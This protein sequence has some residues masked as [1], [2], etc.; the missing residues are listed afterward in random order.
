MIPHPLVLVIGL[1]S[2]FGLTQSVVRTESQPLANNNNQSTPF[3][4]IQ[5][6]SQTSLP[7]STHY[8]VGPRPSPTNTPTITPSPWS[9]NALSTYKDLIDYCDSNQVDSSQW[10]LALNQ[11]SFPS[12]IS[13]ETQE[14]L[15]D[16]VI[17]R[18]SCNFILQ[19]Q[20]RAI[21]L[22]Y[23][24]GPLDATIST[25][26]QPHN[27]SAHYVIDRDGKV[28]QIVPER[29]AAFHVNCYG[30]RNLCIPSC[31][32]CENS[33]GSFVEPRTQTIGI[34]LVNLGHVDPRYYAGSPSAEND[35]LYEDYNNSFGYRFWED[36]PQA[37]IHSLQILVED[38]RSRWDIPLS[39][40]MGHS[41]INNNADPGPALNLFWFRYGNPSREAI[42]MQS[43]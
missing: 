10:R 28:Y 21:V 16:R 43:F 18:P 1:L 20:P 38:I 4:E 5:A 17:I 26:Q 27:S 37:Q 25:F 40:V 24:E 35:G 31:P 23:T 11:V 14:D 7:S 42:F 22:H 33:E 41:R 29:F 12:D 19:N 2:I 9:P 34:E 32:V 3:T 6:T 30:N 39:M 8:T 36:Y 13:N 15:P